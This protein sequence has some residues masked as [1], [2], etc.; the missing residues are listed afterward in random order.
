MN[1][2][3]NINNRFIS[4]KDVYEHYKGDNLN[5]RRFAEDLV[6]YLDEVPTAPI[7]DVYAFYNVKRPT[8]GEWIK[9]DVKAINLI[10]EWVDETIYECSVCGYEEEVT[11]PYCPNCGA[12]L[13]NE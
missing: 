9:K 1:Y 13:E 4:V 2:N 12:R 10:V 11:T 3:P 8:T 6:R 5:D 7:D